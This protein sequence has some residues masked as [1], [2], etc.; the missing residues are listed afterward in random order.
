MSPELVK[1]ILSSVILTI[2]SLYVI[3]VG[4]NIFNFFIIITLFFSI[5]EWRR[6]SK[7]NSKF[8][9]F[10]LVFLLFSFF[11][12]YQLR[13]DFDEGYIYIIFILLICVSTDIGGFVFGR[14][15][16]GPKLTSI[17]PN[18]TYSG[19]IGSYLFSFISAYLYVIILELNNS[20]NYL[21]EILILTFT[22]STI[23]QLGDLVISYFKR[24]SNL[25]D[26]GKIIPGHGGILDRIDGMIFA[27][28]FSHI[29]FSLN[30]FK[31]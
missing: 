21:P 24:A 1:R 20:V 5:F 25:K 19:V 15:L 28:P 9:Y 18:K 11:S 7:N 16:K 10:G 2:L 6:I 12:I 4:G 17:S 23:S 27:F 26:T 30:L 14:I 29:I 22:I 13:N 31:L 3:T 8:R